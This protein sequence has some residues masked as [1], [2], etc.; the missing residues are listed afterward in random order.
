[1]MM[2]M[3]MMMMMMM[4]MV[5]MMMVV[6]IMMMMMS[7]IIRPAPQHVDEMWAEVMWLSHP[8]SVAADELVS[9]MNQMGMDKERPLGLHDVEVVRDPGRDLAVA[10]IN[11]HKVQA[12]RRLHDSLRGSSPF[13]NGRRV[14]VGFTL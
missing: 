8:S 3:M 14:Y 5:V 6:V 2:V 1:M 7:G 13:Y 9:F 12:A 4:I 10:Y 11:C